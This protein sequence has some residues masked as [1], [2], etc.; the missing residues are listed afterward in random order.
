M[1]RGRKPSSDVEKL[2]P[3]AAKQVLRRLIAEGRV[4]AGEV[5]RHV[6]EEVADLR[7]RINLLMGHAGPSVRRAVAGAGAAAASSG[8]KVARKARRVARNVTPERRAAM[9]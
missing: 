6:A 9:A 7:E 1:P 5:S 4:T 2:S 3:E 8:R